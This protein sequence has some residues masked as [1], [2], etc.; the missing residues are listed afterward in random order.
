MDTSCRTMCRSVCGAMSRWACAHSVECASLVRLELCH[1]PNQAGM[2]QSHMAERVYKTENTNP[3][4]PPVPAVL[5]S[6]TYKS[7]RSMYVSAA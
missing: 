6:L 3:E 7:N 2:G 1:N 5:S 4:Q